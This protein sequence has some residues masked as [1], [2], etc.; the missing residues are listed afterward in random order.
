MSFKAIKA[1]EVVS[2]IVALVT[3]RLFAPSQS[4]GDFLETI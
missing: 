2:I 4:K 3:M 1:C